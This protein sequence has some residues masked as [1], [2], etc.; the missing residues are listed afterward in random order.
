[1]D[2]IQFQNFKVQLHPQCTVKNT[3]LN[4]ED[5]VS[6]DEELYTPFERCNMSAPP[7]LQ[8]PAYVRTDGSSARDYYMR[9][10]GPCSQILQVSFPEQ[11]CEDDLHIPRTSLSNKLSSGTHD[12]QDKSAVQPMK[13][14]GSAG[15][16]DNCKEC[17]FF[18]FSAAGCR[19]GV[20]CS[21]CHEFHPRK[22]N[23]KNRRI[24]RTLQTRETHDGKDGQEEHS[25]CHAS[26]ADELEAKGEAV[27]AAPQPGGDGMLR[28]SY[29]K[30]GESEGGATALSLVAGIRTCLRPRLSYA[31]AEG[32]RCLEPTLA[33]MVQPPLPPGLLWDA[34]TGTISGVPEATAKASV[35]IVT[36]KVPAQG[37]GGISLGDV[38]LASCTLIIN[39]RPLENFVVSG[40][41]S[42]EVLLTASDP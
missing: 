39:V 19:N 33:F 18:F 16:P 10:P 5:N 20:G 27:Q 26:K 31:S 12:E 41:S 21:F 14:A 11:I 23:K 40:S 36:V 15:H 22:N 42:A 25:D 4:V 37:Y 2:Q 30:A 28:L 8:D 29:D 13:S 7:V 9:L 6:S 38:P 24:M 35:N 1:M 17:T 32:Q 34:K 3:F